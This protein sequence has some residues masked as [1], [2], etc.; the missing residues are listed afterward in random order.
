MIKKQ[1]GGSS[2]CCERW[3][4]KPDPTWVEGWFVPWNCVLVAAHIHLCWAR[5]R[6]MEDETEGLWILFD[7]LEHKLSLGAADCHWAALE[8]DVD[9]VAIRSTSYNVIPVCIAM[10][11]IL[12][13]IDIQSTI[14]LYPS[15]RS[16]S[17]RRW[18][19]LTTF[20]DHDIRRRAFETVNLM[21]GTLTN[22]P[23]S[24]KF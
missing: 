7:L 17:A 3:S 24:D 18:A 15:F 8:V 1:L 10:V 19:F 5:M 4:T 22:Q 16:P 11:I 23:V 6:A 14:K 9:N 2:P 20:T 12:P 21:N 13:I